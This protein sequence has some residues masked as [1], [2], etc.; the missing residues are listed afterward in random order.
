MFCSS[1]CSFIFQNNTSVCVEIAKCHKRLWQLYIYLCCPNV[2]GTIFMHW[3]YLLVDY[4]ISHRCK[5]SYW[6]CHFIYLFLF[7][8]FLLI[9][10]AMILLELYFRVFQISNN[11]V[12][13]LTLKLKIWQQKAQSKNAHICFWIIS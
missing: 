7:V 13:M 3:A 2:L 10:S 4:W 8:S 9:V 12:V 11:M 6:L 5:F 1:K